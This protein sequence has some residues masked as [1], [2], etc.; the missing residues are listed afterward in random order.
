MLS[1]RGGMVMIRVFIFTI[2]VGLWL[3]L[4][5]TAHQHQY[6]WWAICG[7]NTG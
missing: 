6:P 3:T 4:A 5:Q 7:V 1:D 2:V